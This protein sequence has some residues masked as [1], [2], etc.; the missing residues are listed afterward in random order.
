MLTGADA[1]ADVVRGLDA[2]AND[3]IAKPFR[4]TE[5]LAQVRA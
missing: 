5:L 3:Y 1:E 4:L 2:S